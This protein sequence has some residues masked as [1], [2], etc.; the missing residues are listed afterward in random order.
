MGGGGSIGV[1]SDSDSQHTR[2]S[3]PFAIGIYADTGELEYELTHS[4]EY[5]RLIS[6]Q[7]FDEKY[8]FTSN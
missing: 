3:H 1:V 5:R 4:L 7:S 8:C 6:P 2:P